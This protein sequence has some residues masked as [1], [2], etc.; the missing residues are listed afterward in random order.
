[1]LIFKV[2][3]VYKNVL[4]LKNEKETTR[5][6]DA[7]TKG[8]SMRFNNGSHLLRVWNIWPRFDLFAFP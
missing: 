1:M 6:R 4:I 8:G 7:K 2:N 3:S 5:G